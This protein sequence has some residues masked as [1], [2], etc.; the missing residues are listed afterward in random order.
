MLFKDFLASNLSLESFLF[1]REL[2][3]FKTMPETGF[4][5]KVAEKIYN[6]FIRPETAKMNITYLT[7]ECR[8]W[9]ISP[10]VI[11]R[12]YSVRCSLIC[13]LRFSSPSAASIATGLNGSPSVHVF[14]PAEVVVFEYLAVQKYS[15]FLNSQPFQELPKEVLQAAI[16]RAKKGTSDDNTEEKELDASVSSSKKLT[17]AQLESKQAEMLTNVSLDLILSDPLALSRFRGY[18]QRTLTVE[19]LL[20]YLACEEYRHIPSDTYLKVVANKIFSVFV[21][22]DAKQRVNLPSQI[23]KEIELQ[24]QQQRPTRKLFSRAQAVIFHLLVSEPFPKFLASPEYRAYFSDLQKAAEPQ[25]RWSKFV[26]DSPKGIALP[27]TFSSPVRAGHNRM[28][29]V[30]L[31]TRRD[32][33]SLTARERGRRASAMMPFPRTPPQLPFRAAS[34]SDILSPKK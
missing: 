32:S 17:A 19:N 9:K 2:Q 8:G 3:N 11:A 10:T 27:T 20:F 31:P 5:K 1:W 22:A 25:S 24:M 26:S 28:S 15:E 30:A 34:A 18:L 12:R 23:Y 14:T 13:L 33:Q 16:E 29:V 4:R 21:A 7:P 6:K